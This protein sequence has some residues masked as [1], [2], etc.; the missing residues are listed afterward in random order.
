VNP[1]EV[2]AG[3]VQ[4]VG[5]PEVLRFLAEGATFRHYRLPENVLGYTIEMLFGF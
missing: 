4:A 5:C 3:E 2:A 1:A